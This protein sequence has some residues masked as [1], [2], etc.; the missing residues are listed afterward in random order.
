MF[1]A[2]QQA[3]IAYSG[4]CG[5]SLYSVLA[6]SPV[7]WR[8]QMRH[9]EGD[10]RHVKEIIG[11]ILLDHIALVA[12]AHDEIVDAMTGIDLHDVPKDRLAA[13]FDHWL[14]LDACFFGNTCTE[15]TG[16]YHCSHSFQFFLGS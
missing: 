3:R 15:P 1:D 6:T 13:D 14:G 7:K 11:E 16:E 12:A 8:A 9:I 5:F 10:V 4:S 2:Q